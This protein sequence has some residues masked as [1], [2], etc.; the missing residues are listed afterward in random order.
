MVISLSPCAM[1]QRKFAERG[2]NLCLFLLV[3]CRSTIMLLSAFICVG[4]CGSIAPKVRCTNDHML[5]RRIPAALLLRVDCA[6]GVCAY[7]LLQPHQYVAVQMLS[8]PL[9]LYTPFIT[10]TG[11]FL[12]SGGRNPAFT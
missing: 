11:Q 8:A 5:Y 9:P 3:V 6:V 4:A 1:E 7:A 2:L 12:K 10:V